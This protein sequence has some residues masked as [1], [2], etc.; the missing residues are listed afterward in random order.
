M[1]PFCAT[2][3]DPKPFR[4]KHIPAL[5]FVYF[6]WAIGTV[7]VTG[8]ADVYADETTAEQVKK[9]ELFDT[10][11]QAKNQDEG[12]AAESAILSLIHI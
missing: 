1:F 12:R 10:L 9:A 11:L 3:M 4:L 6:C 2:P 5:A 8:T 7:I